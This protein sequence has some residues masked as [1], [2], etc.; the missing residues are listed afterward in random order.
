MRNVR[1]RR[2]RN[3][4]KGSLSERE[5]GKVEGIDKRSEGREGKKEKGRRKGGRGGKKEGRDER[6]QCI[7]RLYNSHS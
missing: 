7:S 2:V 5:E 4:I 6:G 3:R 1:L